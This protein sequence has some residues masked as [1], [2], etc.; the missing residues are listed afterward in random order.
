MILAAQL[1]K[2]LKK[3][4]LTVAK[5]SRA[6]GVSQKTLHSWLDSKTPSNLDSVKKIANYFDLTLEELLF[7]EVPKPKN[8]LEEYHDEIQAGIFEV[9]LK[10]VKK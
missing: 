7:G 6:T 8:K 3:H 4:D 1:K 2:L 5:L 9:I 10:R